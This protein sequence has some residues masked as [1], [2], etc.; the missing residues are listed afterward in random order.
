MDF[1]DVKKIFAMK[2]DTTPMTNGSIAPNESRKSNETYKQYGFRMAGISQGVLQTFTPHLQSVYLGLKKEQEEDSS[3]QTELQ[4]SLQNKKVILEKDK[5]IEANKLAQNEEKLKS[6]EKDLQEKQ[7]E[8]AELKIAGAERNKSAWVTLIISST[9]LIPYTLYFFIFYS[10]VAYSAFFKQ[11]SLENFGANG[12]FQ[13]SEAIFDSHALSAAA[14]EGATTLLFILL[15][16]IIFLAFGFVLNRWEMETGWLKYIKIPLIIVVAFIFDT[17]LSYAICEKI[18]NLNRL[19]SLEEL[20]PYSFSLAS[21]DPN[22]WVII[23]LGFVAYLIWGITFGYFVKSLDQLDLNTIRL[24]QIRNEIANIQGKMDETRQAQADNTANI[25]SICAE[26][27]KVENQQNGTI[28][29]YDVNKIKMELNNFLAG[30]QQYMATMLKTD[31][32]K[33]CIINEFNKTINTL[34]TI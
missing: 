8:V 7:N 14:L 6:L 1:T 17:L 23:C 19:M 10:S 15:M 22:F 33:N 4:L 34:I 2:N 29:R 28:A 11:F 18:Y 30:W 27:S 12:N 5:E 16:P 26:I 13:L 31:D 3:L 20:P 24:E 25:A 21:N 9:I 32:E